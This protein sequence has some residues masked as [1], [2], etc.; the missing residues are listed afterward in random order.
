MSANIDKTLVSQIAAAKA[1]EAG[2]IRQALYDHSGESIEISWIKSTIPPQD[3]D[4]VSMT[5]TD[6]TSAVAKY[7]T[8]VPKYKGEKFTVQPLIDA[9]G[10]HLI[11]TNSDGE[12]SFMAL[13]PSHVV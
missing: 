9:T 13:N 12:H 5:V 10:V 6:W 3:N 1:Y 4:K 2:I 8:E 7:I 11:N